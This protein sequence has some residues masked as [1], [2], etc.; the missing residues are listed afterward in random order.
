MQSTPL[1][2][3]CILHH[4]LH[5]KCLILVGGLLQHC[6]SSCSNQ[7]NQVAFRWRDKLDTLLGVTAYCCF[8]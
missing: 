1:V 8:Q 5:Q 6:T 3:P 2:Q 7:T 4:R